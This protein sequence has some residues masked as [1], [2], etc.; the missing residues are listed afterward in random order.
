VQ[1]PFVTLLTRALSPGGVLRLAT[2]WRP[3]ALDMLAALGAAPELTN[4]AADGGFVARPA[5]RLPTRFEL[6]GL[7]LGHEVWDLALRRR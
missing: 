6:R 7:R 5:E 4:L 1:A 2:D 3:Y